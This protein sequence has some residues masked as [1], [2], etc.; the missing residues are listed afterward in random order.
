M[1]APFKCKT[2]VL[3]FLGP[4]PESYFHGDT[5][6]L[7]SVSAVA[8]ML[9]IV[10]LFLAWALRSKYK[11]KEPRTSI[12]EALLASD[13]RSSDGDVPMAL[14]APMQLTQIELPIPRP[15]SPPVPRSPKLPIHTRALQIFDVLKLIL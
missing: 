13:S 15:P 12:Q 11:P 9:T 5:V 2:R 6:V 3:A 4:G 7:I 8:A 10:V 14:P 1:Y